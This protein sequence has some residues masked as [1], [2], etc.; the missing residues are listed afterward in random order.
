MA[1]WVRQD[2]KSREPQVDD[3]SWKG[4]LYRALDPATLGP[5]Q[6]PELSDLLRRRPRIAGRATR[7]GPRRWTRAQRLPRPSLPQ[8]HVVGPPRYERVGAVRF[9]STADRACRG[10]LLVRRS[11]DWRRVPNSPVVE[12]ALSAR[13]RVARSSQRL[14]VWHRQDKYNRTTFD[15]VTTTGLRMT[16]ELQP[17]F[18]GGIL[19][20]KVDA[21]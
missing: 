3:P 2:G 12:A 1:V 10:G 13:R 18:S 9:R 4:R 17:E 15:P 11:S 8:T 16:V 14:G 19:E 5:S 21:K 7:R 6:P 20:W